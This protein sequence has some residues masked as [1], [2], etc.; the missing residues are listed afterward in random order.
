MRRVT[1]SPIVPRDEFAV[2]LERE[3]LSYFEET[4]FTPIRNLLPD[5]PLGEINALKISLLAGTIGY[6]DGEF[7]GAFHADISRELRRLGAVR[8]IRGFKFNPGTM[9]VPLRAFL[10]QMKVRNG[11]THMQIENALVLMLEVI[12]IAATGIHVANTIDKLVPDLQMQFAKS[13][14]T[15]EGLDV[16]A[17]LSESYVSKIRDQVSVETDFAVRNFTRQQ[18]NE[19]RSIVY[20]NAREGGRA[21]RLRELIETQYGVAKRKARIIAESETSLATARFRRERYQTFGLTQYIWETSHDEKVRP[22]H[23]ESNN[24][25]I[26]DGRTF[27]WDVPPVVDAATGRRRHPGEDYGPCRC[28]ARPVVI[29]P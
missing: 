21:D 17:K 5:S 20:Q 7:R 1:L 29:L 6:V 8:T 13:V 2:P 24:H 9:P 28:V 18:I 12:A 16:P 11:E 27:S 22:T 23:G 3:I 25:R 15:V 19:L 10:S 4:I 26:L 14:S